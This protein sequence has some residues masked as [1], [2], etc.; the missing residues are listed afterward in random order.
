M[1]MASVND[2][3]SIVEGTAVTD[4]ATARPM[5]P[6]P[7]ESPSQLTP[8]TPSRITRTYSSRTPR[9]SA[10]SPSLASPSPSQPIRRTN[11]LPTGSALDEAHL[12]TPTKAAKNLSTLFDFSSPPHLLGA[13]VSPGKA[14]GGLAKRMLSKSRTEP[15]LESG[16]ASGSFSSSSSSLSR[17]QPAIGNPSTA[18]GL[19]KSGGTPTGSSFG[20]NVSPSH[21]PSQHQL[22]VTANT[23]TYAGKSRSFL[24][25]LPASN[26]P[27][28]AD[29]L[30]IL[31]PTDEDQEEMELR[32]SYADLRHRWGVDNSEDDP[33][34]V[35]PSPSPGRNKGKAR[36]LGPLPSGMMN[37][38]KSI[39]E[40]RSKGESR[41]FLD[42]VGYLFEGL[43][44]N[45]GITR[46]ESLNFFVYSA[47]EITLKLCD[48][49]FAR[50]A[51][52]ADFLGRTWDVLRLAGAG[53]GDK[54]LNIILVFFTAL[55]ARDSGSLADL[56]QK[57]DFG[58]TLFR[59]LESCDR[60]K[61]ILGMVTA[62]ASDAQL[63]Q[64]G[65]L[66]TERPVLTTLSNTI[67][68]KSGIFHEGV[69]VS[70]R[71]LIS[72]TLVTLPPSMLPPQFLST[73]R[74][75]LVSELSLVPPRVMAYISGLSILP[76]S[77][78]NEP[79]LPSFEHLNNMLHMLDTFLLGQ[80]MQDQTQVGKESLDGD[81]DCLSDG[82]IAL[83]V[84][85]EIISLD[86]GVADRRS[87]SDACLEIALKVLVNLSHDDVPW[88]TSLIRNPYTLPLVMRLV[89]RS[90]RERSVSAVK[91][92]EEELLAD[93]RHAHSLDRL[94]LGLGLLTNIIQVIDEAKD[95]CREIRIDPA[96]RAKRQCLSACCCSQRISGLECL[97]ALYVQQMKLEDAG[98]NFLRGHIAVL[99]GLLMRGCPANQ[100]VLLDA[101]PGRSNRDK[102]SALA[103]QASEFVAFYAQLTV[104]L[105]AAKG[106]EVHDESDA[107]IPSD[108]DRGIEQ[109]V[110]DG[111]GEVVARDVV[112]FLRNL[113]D[114]DMT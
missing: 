6:P 114:H 10:S 35:S 95:L 65:I 40:L 55:V 24:V 63:K 113:H 52:A 69:P 109:N 33:R 56:A 110:R 18:Q 102:L 46:E 1:Q 25:A 66:R 20:D 74:H 97:V 93:D 101:L 7:R 37:D 99:F 98:A 4:V 87:H 28:V 39:T 86:N 15:S 64:A 53:D 84:T 23:R 27:S 47:L 48:A 31:N 91:K 60:Q 57:S 104:Q 105:A 78:V 3:P 80:W 43:D 77:Q 8:R 73:L 106:T 5:T 112:D 38:L 50:K 29:P 96:C 61:D 2:S 26:V 83:C 32:E 103:D 11:T 71:L 19:A 107:Y 59:L 54:I 82:L 9:G 45:G 22:P 90:D 49:D 67:V 30:S 72:H 85:T 68:K 94:C 21:S 14:G 51:K 81:R 92:E 111:K 89:A 79:D 34:P 100:R 13:T 58:P 70:T 88:S 75:S 16:S 41:R 62:G 42:E 76:A 108:G 44:S 36:A 12:S 17:K